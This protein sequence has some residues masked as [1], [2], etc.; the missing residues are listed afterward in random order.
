MFGL[1]V[2]IS[3]SLQP[4]TRWLD[5]DSAYS[6][7]NMLSGTSGQ[8]RWYA[9]MSN[10]G[11]VSGAMRLSPTYSHQYFLT[12][13]GTLPG[14]TGEGW[15]DAG[16]SALAT[17]PAA[18]ETSSTSRIRLTAYSA[19]GGSLFSLPNLSFNPVNISF[20]MNTPHTLQFSSKLQYS[21]TNILET[22]SLVSMTPSATGGFWYDNGATVYIVLYMSWDV[23]GSTRQGL[24]SYSIDSK[25]MSVDRTSGN[26]VYVPVITMAESHVLTDGSVTQY[27]IS[28]EG[29][30]LSGSQ[31]QDGWF[32]FGSQFAVQGSYTQSYTANMPYHVYA[33]PVGFQI[34]ANTT[35]SSVLWTSS[36][37]TL[38]FNA[39]HVEAAVY[40]PEELNLTPRTVSD[41]GTPLVFSYS[42]SSHMLSFKG[43][44]GFQIGLSSTT[45]VGSLLS[46]IP[47]WVLYTS[48][49][50]VAVGVVLFLGLVLMKRQARKTSA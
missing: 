14:S 20:Q 9:A 6:L 47:D 43:S 7:T 21:L 17:S 19:D 40:I 13:T 29:A 33:V 16:S 22:N 2:P 45:R 18:Y 25:A 30:S 39:N 44:S 36:S 5:A 38:S 32:D 28:V 26:V 1:S 11:F 48:T 8:E 46:T 50:V 37:G 23:V 12:V 24:V 10:P 49:I 31:T 27:F 4:S 41:D 35:V 34:V 42:S 3:L 15:Y